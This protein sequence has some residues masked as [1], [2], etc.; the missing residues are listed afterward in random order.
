M[1]TS[2]A[3][4]HCHSNYSFQEGASSI[5]ELLVRAHELGY[6]ALALTDH[7]NLCG[8]MELAQVARSVGIHAITGAEVTLKGGSHVTLLAAT[9]KGY[10]NLCRLISYAHISAGRRSPELDP[11]HIPE[12]AEGLLLLTGCGKGPVPG[13]LMEG[14][15]GE[16]EEVLRR[17]LEWFGAPNV[18]VEL[19][20]NLVQGDTQRNRRLVELASKLGSGVVAT[21]N[22]H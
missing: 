18:Y 12:H 22:V 8:A 3:E 1:S 16:A 20:R 6:R 9:Q 5:G 15:Y 2:Y 11:K 19:Q 21:N 14:R 17:Y 13:L 4:L 10:A 7:D